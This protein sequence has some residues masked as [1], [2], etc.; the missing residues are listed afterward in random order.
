MKT[1]MM[2]AAAFALAVLA[3]GCKKHVDTGAMSVTG[4]ATSNSRMSD[5]YDKVLVEVLSVQAHYNDENKGSGGWV[6]LASQTGVYDLMQ[7][8]NDVTAMLATQGEL[9]PGKI[10]QLRLIL[11][12][13]DSIVVAGVTHP[14]IVASGMQSGIKINVDTS[15]EPKK[16]TAIVLDFDID[17]SVVIEGS[18]TYSLKPVIK[19]KSVTQTDI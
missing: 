16:R 6:N 17:K 13:H 18:G 10:S 2:V 14:I 3:T 7:L 19:V 15:I 11:G 1:K 9:A 5:S 12:S 8:R 4:T